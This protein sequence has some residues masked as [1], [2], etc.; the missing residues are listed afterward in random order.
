MDA[1]ESERHWLLVRPFVLGVQNKKKKQA[2]AQENTA[3]RRELR[4]RR[5]V[6]ELA[7]DRAASF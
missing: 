1:V 7:Q 2:T 5:T 4:R 3:R 6:E